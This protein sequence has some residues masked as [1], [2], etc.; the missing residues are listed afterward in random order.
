MEYKWEIQISIGES[1]EAILVLGLRDREDCSCA[2]VS[3]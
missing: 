1:D 3:E 2:E